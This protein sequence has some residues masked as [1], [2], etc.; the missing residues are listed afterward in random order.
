MTGLESGLDTQTV[1]MIGTAA[2][3]TVG[4]I[5][6][7]KNFFQPKSKKVWTLVM[8][9]LSLCFCAVYSYLPAW[10]TAG[11]LAIC[12]CQL[13]WDTVLQTFKKIVSKIGGI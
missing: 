7:L 5:E 12:A 13:C 1:Q 2:M 10:V 9:P 4:S 8:I 3:E 11:I 6:M